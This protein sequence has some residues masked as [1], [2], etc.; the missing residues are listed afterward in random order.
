MLD[1]P[2]WKDNPSQQR[3][4]QPQTV[5]SAEGAKSRL[6][7][8]PPNLHVPVVSKRKHRSTIKLGLRRFYSQ[9]AGVAHGGGGGGGVNILWQSGPIF[10]WKRVLRQRF[11]KSHLQ[12]T[13]EAN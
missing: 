4:S 2:L 6:A 5:P 1:I 7:K 12:P 11:G 8:Q 13:S 10:V 3:A 9:R